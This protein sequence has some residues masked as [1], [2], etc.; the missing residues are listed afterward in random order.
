[1]YVC[2]LHLFLKSDES[3]LQRFEQLK[4]DIKIVQSRGTLVKLA[5]GGEEW[6]NSKTFRKSAY[7]TEYTANFVSDIG[8]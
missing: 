3:D 5:Y 8:R 7:W 1:M 4:Q 6:G 2:G